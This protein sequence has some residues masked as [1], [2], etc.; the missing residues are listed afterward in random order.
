MAREQS[1]K[2]FKKE[3]RKINEST[4]NHAGFSQRGAGIHG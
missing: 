1:F 3:H 4:L 2:K